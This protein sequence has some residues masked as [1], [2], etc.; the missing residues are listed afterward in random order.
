MP[1]IIRGYDFYKDKK[2]QKALLKFS[3]EAGCFE[4]LAYLI[5]V[6]CLISG[7]KKFKKKET[8]DDYYFIDEFDFS[9]LTENEVRNYFYENYFCR[10]SKFC[11]NISHD[12]KM[13][14]YPKEEK[15]DS[16]DKQKDLP[17]LFLENKKST[18][19]SR[20]EGK[21]YKA[22]LDVDADLIKYLSMSAR[23]IESL[24]S[25]N[26]IIFDGFFEKNKMFKRKDKKNI[27]NKKEIPSF[28]KIESNSTTIFHDS[29]TKQNHEDSSNNCCKCSIL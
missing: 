28:K 20:S 6:N 8:N 4:S 16:K 27:D 14:C 3:S 25:A 10:A 21:D 7:G 2:F 1:L 15:K 5:D 18:P 11:I 26:L 19:R 9:N 24:L 22:V 23:D 12:Q 17:S 13:S 29:A